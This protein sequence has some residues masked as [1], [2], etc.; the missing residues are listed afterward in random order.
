M[1]AASFVRPNC[2]LIN[3][4][5]EKSRSIEKLKMN[6]ATRHKLLDLAF[7]RNRVFYFKPRE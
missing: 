3:I 7:Q 6:N 4:L 2:E 1:G 5:N